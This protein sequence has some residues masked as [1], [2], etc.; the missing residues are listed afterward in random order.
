MKFYQRND[1]FDDSRSF[2]SEMIKMNPELGGLDG[3]ARFGTQILYNP[4]LDE[5]VGSAPGT[6][7]G[8]GCLFSSEKEF[9]HR[10][11]YSFYSV[12]DLLL[13]WILFLYFIFICAFNFE[14]C[15][16]F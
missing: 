14:F 16:K 1:L 8:Q 11:R 7:W 9:G 12:S 13:F 5:L 15:S 3:T 4:Q 10:K 2:V 6:A